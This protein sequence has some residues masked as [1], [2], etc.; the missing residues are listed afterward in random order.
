MTIYEALLPE[1]NDGRGTIS[2]GF[3]TS[4]EAAR[5]RADEGNVCG[6]PVPGSVREV[7]AH[8]TIEH[9]RAAQRDEER[10]RAL[11]KLSPRERE[12]LG[13]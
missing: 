13:L 8:G 6:T 12:L 9:Y 1:P 5:R 3:F 10:K 7:V 11:A 4:L 2:G